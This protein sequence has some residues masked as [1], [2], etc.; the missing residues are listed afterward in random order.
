MRILKKVYYKNAYIKDENGYNVRIENGDVF[1]SKTG[2][3]HYSIE[4]LS[5]NELSHLQE[6]GYIVNEI[7]HDTHDDNIRKLKEVINNPN[8]SLHNLLSAYIAGF[9]SY[10]RGR[11]PIVSYLFAQAVPVHTFCDTKGAKVCDICHMTNE[12]WLEKG[13]EI[14]QNY[15]GST[16]NEVA[17]RFYIDLE[18]FAGLQP[19]APTEEDLQIFLAVIDM[20][21]NAPENE[22]PGQ[23]EQ[24]IKKSKIVPKYEKYWMRGQLMAL[25][26]LGVMPNPF[27]KPL[28]DEFTDLTTL[29]EIGR[30]VPGGSRSD[31]IL[32]LSGWR[33]QYGICEERFS[34]LFGVFYA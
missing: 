29:C 15:S 17:G 3:W 9:K 16:W 7:V 11:Q 30:K 10:P 33:G 22:T 8:L 2:K 23:L 18:E 5:P 13:R 34:K 31:I 6:S 32:P 21:R 1:D 24:R 12:F 14:F 27:V 20:I 28:L 26:E 4:N 25:A 19:Q